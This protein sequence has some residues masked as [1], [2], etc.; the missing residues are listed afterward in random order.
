MSA[1]HAFTQSQN[2]SLPEFQ[3]AQFAFTAHIRDPQHFAKPDDIEERRIA[4]Y[5]ELL[6]NNVQNFIEVGFPILR[7]MLADD[8]WQQ[9]LR[10]FFAHHVSHSPYFTDI[11]AEFVQYLA[12]E[13]PADVA[14]NWPFLIELAHY[15][16]MELVALIADVELPTPT[17]DWSAEHSRLQLSP[18]AWP[19]A[20]QYPVQRIGPAFLPETPTPTSLVVYRNRADNVEFIELAGMTY[21][22][23]QAISEQA[24]NLNEIAMQLQT[25]QPQL[26][27]PALRNAMLPVV[28]DFIQREIL[29]SV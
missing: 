5:R 14:P 28:A 7:S 15:E 16:W 2:K 4:I 9:L 24:L 27:V 6:F 22:L 25:H 8:V 26:T 19:L 11:S 29:F 17:P 3:R 21:L 13:K 23:L 1:T 18:L 10:H 20:Y 12:T